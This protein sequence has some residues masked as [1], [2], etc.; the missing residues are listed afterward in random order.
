MDRKPYNPLPIASEKLALDNMLAAKGR[1]V[2]LIDWEM[3]E[4]GTRST[5]PQSSFI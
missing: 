1:C 3:V 5:R 4:D 2:E